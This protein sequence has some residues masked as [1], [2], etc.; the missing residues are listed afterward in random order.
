MRAA[1]TTQSGIVLRELDVPVPDAG[2]VLVR[3]LACGICGSDLHAAADLAHFV[4]LTERAGAPG[5]LDPARGAVFGHEFSAEIVEYGPGA[6]RAL[7]L[8]TT[9]C[10]VPI[11]FG[12]GGVE[13]IGYSSAV[14][15]GLAEFMLLQEMFLVPVP[16]G[17]GPETAALTEP[18]AVGEHAVNLAGVT[19]GDVCLVIGCGPVGLAVITALKAR[20]HGPIVAVDFSPTRRRIAE[21][22]GADEV[23]DPAETSPYDS[24]GALG[25]PATL[26]ERAA[27]EMFGGDSRD[28]VIF[29]AVGSPGVLQTIID[30][31]P[32]KA[33][34][35]V[36]GVCMQTDRIEPFF[37]VTKELEVRFSF[38]YSPAEFS[39]TLDRLGRGEIPTADFVTD[40]VS[41]D[42]A[43]GAF[44][45][46]ASPGEHGKMIVRH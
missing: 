43:A 20:G 12:A 27:A 26:M 5:G 18:L 2:Q 40:V 17:L 22:F 32:P 23:I 46:L 38:G 10:S 39:A 36:V 33:R 41:L 28:A 21:A 29:E 7:P 16:A 14:H 25:V 24:W 3:T 34:I 31:A 44:A 45:A 37:A 8:G 1:V 30:G 6:T 9:V 35:V 19:A 13:G 15:G 11:L 42:G 4:E